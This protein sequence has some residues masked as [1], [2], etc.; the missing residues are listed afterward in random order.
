MIYRPFLC[1]QKQTSQP[2]DFVK[3]NLNADTFDCSELYQFVQDNVIPVERRH[4]NDVH[5][6]SFAIDSY[7]CLNALNCVKDKQWFYKY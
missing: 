1:A 2:F 4:F 3:M 5:P 6:F 7:I